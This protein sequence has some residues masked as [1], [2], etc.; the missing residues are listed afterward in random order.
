LAESEARA[1]AGGKWEIKGYKIKRLR[2]L[3]TP[4]GVQ[5][6]YIWRHPPWLY[7]A[8]TPPAGSPCNHWILQHVSF[9]EII[10]FRISGV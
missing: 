7:T 9:K 2:V 3:S 10:L 5:P 6:P 4:L 1:V 8:S